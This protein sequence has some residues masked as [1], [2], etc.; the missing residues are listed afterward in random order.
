MVRTR[1]LAELERRMALFPHEIER[2]EAAVRADEMGFGIHTSQVRVLKILMDELVERQRDFLER[3]QPTLSDAEFAD[4]VDALMFEEMTGAHKIWSVFS[5][6]FADRR[7]PETAP[8]L[9]TADLVAADCYL[10]CTGRARNWGMLEADGLR[11]PPLVC[12]E[13]FPE[14][15]ALGRSDLLG[16]LCDAGWRF[17]ELR[18]P[19]PLVILPADQVGC[20]WLLPALGHEVGHD[21]DKDLGLSTELERAIFSSESGIA[22]ERR[23]AWRRW[24]AEVLADAFGLLLGNVGFAHSLAALI[25][26]LAPG[27]RYV[28]LNL[29][30]THPHPLLRVHLLGAMLRRLGP[31]TLAAAAALLEDEA[32]AVRA[33]EGIAPF[34]SDV[35]AVA[36]ILLETRLAGLGGH[37]LSE[38]NP[39]LAADAKRATLLAEFLASGE[40]RPSPDHPSR[41]PYRLVPAAAQLAVMTLNQGSTEQLA[42]VQQRATDFVAAIPRPPYLADT[43]RLTSRRAGFLARLAREM[44]LGG[45]GLR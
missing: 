35:D 29:A 18:L 42:A 28:E 15:I 37:P 3:L 25:L 27:R 41:F 31:P 11:E 43:A 19:I 23:E 7:R 20:V 10:L 13:T 24:T 38:L 8:H 12:L 14:A 33:P 30:V 5:Q 36:G 9:D 44:N 40:L 17:H 1:I 34:L 39:E 2:L 22:P 16:A 21:V 6:A 32:R 4:G 45:G 26:L